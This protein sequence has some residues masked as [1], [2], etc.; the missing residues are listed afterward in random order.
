[1]ATIT[2]YYHGDMKFE[3]V[4]GNHKLIIDVPEGMGGQDR[5]PQ[6]P[7]LFIASIGSCVAA[8]IAEYCE[9]HDADASDM[10]VDVSFKKEPN[11]TRL[12][13]IKVKVT[14]PHVSWQDKRQEEA[15]KRVAQHCPVHQTIETVDDIE[16]EIIGKGTDEKALA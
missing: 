1:M 10:H 4:M 9:H 5:G 12:T 2:T 7:Q 13:N 16:F 6:P 11:P 14:L 15:L 8:L 3:T